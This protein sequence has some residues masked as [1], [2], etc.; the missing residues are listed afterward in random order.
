MEVVSSVVRHDT[1]YLL[2]QKQRGARFWELL[3]GKLEESDDTPLEGI[4]R[5]FEEELGHSMED[6]VSELKGFEPYEIE[7]GRNTYKVYPNEIKLSEQIEPEISDEHIDYDWFTRSELK[8]MNEK[9]IFNRPSYET[10][11]YVEFPG[12]E[13]YDR[14]IGQN[15]QTAAF[16]LSRGRSIRGD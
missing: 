1:D 16:K 15:P 2:L 6:C 4:S 5:E 13:R 8:E 12:E 11:E 3:G 9:E 10:L 7:T 14:F